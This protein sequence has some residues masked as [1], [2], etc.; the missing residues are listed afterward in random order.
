MTLLVEVEGAEEAAR[1]LTI[2]CVGLCD[3]LIAGRLSVEEAEGHLFSPHTFHWLE[4]CHVDP[5][6]I[7]LVLCGM[8]LEDVLSLLPDDYPAALNELRDSALTLLGELP[9]FGQVRGRRVFPRTPR[10]R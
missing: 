5:G 10:E 1:L 3:G 9:G 2:L 8:E 6:V 4:K 7:R